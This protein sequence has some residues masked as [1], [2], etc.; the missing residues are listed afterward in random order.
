MNHP[1]PRP[2]TEDS[3]EKRTMASQLE[4]RVR[5]DIINGHLAPGSKLR[6]KELAESYDAGV[7]PLREALS[8]LAA[9]GFITVE[10]QKG[11]RV[12]AI[13]AEEIRDITN[14]RLH[15]ETKALAE[16]ILQG[17]VEWESRLIAA[18]HRLD[19]LEL[20]E[21]PERLMRPEWEQAHDAF[22][23]ALIG[24]CR[25]AWL[26]RLASTLRDQTAR[27]RILAMHYPEA[28][29]RDIPGEHRQLLHACLSKDVGRAC[30]LLRSHYEATTRS[31]LEHE[32]LAR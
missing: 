15:I 31:V 24:G 11:F 8:R 3:H 7:I 19:R 23:S 5:Q 10:D 28:A 18:H 1:L 14:A 22:H 25:S 16:S 2:Q 29:K 4:V 20:V 12:G 32:R 9:V 13:S 6:L 17:D 27:Y 26:Q 30:E 21:G